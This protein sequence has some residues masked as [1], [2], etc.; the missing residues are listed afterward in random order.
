MPT[1]YPHKASQNAL[2]SIQIRKNVA[3]GSIDLKMTSNLYDGCLSKSD[4]DAK[5]HGRFAAE[6]IRKHADGDELEWIKAFV[7]TMNAGLNQEG[8]TP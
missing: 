4:F 2:L 8:V 6:F 1:K 5:R 7:G 3:R